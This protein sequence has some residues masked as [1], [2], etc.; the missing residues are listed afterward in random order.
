[1]KGVFMKEIIVLN[2][3]DLGLEPA[4]L[5]NPDTRVAARGIVINKDNKIAILNKKNNNEYKLVGGGVDEN[6]DPKSAFK[7]EVLE[8][9][10]CKI[11]IDDFLGIVKEERTNNNFIQTS[12]IYV[13][14]VIEDTKKLNLTQKE[15]DEGARLIWLDLDEAINIIKECE[16][17]I[18]A[19]KY[20]NILSKRFVIKRDYNI[21][22]YYRDNYLK[23]ML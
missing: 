17:N 19:S 1:M 6:E 7:R 18:K 15:I 2:E 14:H 10:G 5:N 12:Y 9:A 21:L 22:V 11:E 4:E 8:E 20:E 23:K 3:K 16:N 13:A